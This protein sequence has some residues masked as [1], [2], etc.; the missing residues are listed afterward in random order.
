MDRYRIDGP[1]MVRGGSRGFTILAIGGVVQPLVGAAAPLVGAIWLVLVAVAAFVASAWS[2]HVVDVV[3]RQGAASALLGYA[4]I[5]PVVHMATG[6]VDP[7]Q[8]LWTSVTAAVVGGATGLIRA[9][10]REARVD[11]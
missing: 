9:K 1:T 11:G 7:T 5:V 10:C 8:L 6:S 4:L 3:I 2:A